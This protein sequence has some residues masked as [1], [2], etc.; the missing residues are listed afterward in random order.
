M[1]LYLIEELAARAYYSLYSLADSSSGKRRRM[2]AL[3]AHFAY[4]G[5]MAALLALYAFAMMVAFSAILLLNNPQL[6]Y[7]LAEA[8]YIPPIHH[9]FFFMFGAVAWKGKE[10]TC[11]RRAGRLLLRAFSPRSIRDE[12]NAAA[13]GNAVEATCLIL[14]LMPNRVTAAKIAYDLVYGA[15]EVGLTLFLIAPLLLALLPLLCLLGVL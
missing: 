3:L 6:Y 7:E 2:A 15:T 10:T 1:V 4:Y 14:S 12:I 13:E 9:L 8:Q 5:T 11:L